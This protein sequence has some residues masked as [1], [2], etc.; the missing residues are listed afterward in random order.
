MEDAIQ[1]MAMGDEDPNA[2]L[3]TDEIQQLRNL[4]GMFKQ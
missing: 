4:L 2:S 1:Q 3:A